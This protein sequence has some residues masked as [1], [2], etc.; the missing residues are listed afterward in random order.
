MRLSEIP[1]HWGDVE[2]NDAVVLIP[3]PYQTGLIPPWLLWP[4]LLPFILLLPP[5]PA[6]VI[7]GT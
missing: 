6:A 2:R 7:A 4:G 5:A 3:E 1:V